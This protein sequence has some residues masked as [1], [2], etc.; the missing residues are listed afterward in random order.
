MIYSKGQRGTTSREVAGGVRGILLLSG[1]EYNKLMTKTDQTPPKVTFKF[2]TYDSK[3]SDCV[4]TVVAEDEAFAWM[5][6]RGIYGDR[7]VDFVSRV[8]TW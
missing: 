6:F 7:P 5:R 4:I 1:S 2:Y 8:V 3:G